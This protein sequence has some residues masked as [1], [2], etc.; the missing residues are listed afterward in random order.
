MSVHAMELKV[1]V[2]SRPECQCTR[3]TTRSYLGSVSPQSPHQRQMHSSACCLYPAHVQAHTRLALAQ[4]ERASRRR[5]R[6]EAEEDEEVARAEGRES[7]G[8][9]VRQWTRW[10]LRICCCASAAGVR[11]QGC[12]LKHGTQA[13]VQHILVP[14]CPYAR[15]CACACRAP[16]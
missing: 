3:W 13:L 8:G 2:H 11:Q 10:V 15:A 16:A 9:P 6:K 7:G 1:D 4:A 5:T 14:S 12:C